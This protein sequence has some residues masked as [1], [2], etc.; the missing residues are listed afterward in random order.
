MDIRAFEGAPAMVDAIESQRNRALTDHAL[1]VGHLSV[2]N[3][4]NAA[5]AAENLEVKKARDELTAR[6]ADL[7][8]KL[9]ELAPVQEA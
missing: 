8:A 4:K 7:E 2:A 9:H 6:V 3:A 5:L 1:A